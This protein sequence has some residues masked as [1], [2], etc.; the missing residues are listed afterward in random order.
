MGDAAD[1]LL[2]TAATL[3][4][5]ER[6]GYPASRLV[7]A[8]DGAP[9]TRA[10]GW[11]LLM[12]SF[13]AGEVPAY[14]LVA[15]RA[16]GALVGRLH[17]LDPWA[18]SSLAPVPPAP[19]QPALEVPALLERLAALADRVP[20][21]LRAPYDGLVAALHR[22]PQDADLPRAII[23]TDCHLGNAIQTPRGDLVMIDWDGAGV[24]PA[25][26]DVGYLLITCDKGLPRLP[27]VQPDPERI[28]AL[29]T[30]YLQQRALSAT[31]RAALP[32]AMRAGPLTHGGWRL[33]NLLEG[34]EPAD[35]WQ[36]W[37]ARFQAVE[38]VAAM[39]REGM[40]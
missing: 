23:H 9:V 13:V 21:E 31:E 8:L 17:N 18:S 15:L 2:A 7:L 16:L 3:D 39:A 25:V 14:S 10:E 30:G 36:L 29:L 19:R 37:W 40:G 12:T 26:L 22:I 5:L 11:Q 6:Q 38:E 20:P 4:H 35:A 33:I 24:G 1:W 27:R 34:R 32:G 28:S